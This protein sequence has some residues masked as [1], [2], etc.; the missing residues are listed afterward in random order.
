MGSAMVT[1]YRSGQMEPD[2]KD[3]G[4]TTLLQEEEDSST[5]MEISMM[6]REKQRVL[7]QDAYKLH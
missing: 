7:H 3:S 2:T 1:V 5:L 6:V 4:G